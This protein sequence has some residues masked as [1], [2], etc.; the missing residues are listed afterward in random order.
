MQQRL[1]A[2]TGKPVEP[3][4]EDGSEAASKRLAAETEKI[5]AEKGNNERMTRDVEDSL[6]EFR[7]TVE[8]SLNEI[9][10]KSSTSSSE[11][12][13]RRWEDALGVEDEVKDF[14]FELQRQSRGAKTRRDESVSHHNCFCIVINVVIVI[15]ITAR[16]EVTRSSNVALLLLGPMKKLVL[17][18][19]QLARPRPHHLHPE[20][21]ILHFHPLKSVLLISSNKPSKRWLSVSPPW[22]LAIL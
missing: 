21:L 19:R 22:V 12:E 4:S 6:N 1:A 10:G 20:L 3:V 7:R 15:V 13:K 16:V 11:H 14:I 17:P 8:A 5:N 2:L 9:G 18:P